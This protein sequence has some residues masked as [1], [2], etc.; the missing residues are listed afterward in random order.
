MV[1]SISYAALLAILVAGAYL[2]TNR[3]DDPGGA[4]ELYRY[5][6]VVRGD[7]TMTVT[8]TGRVNPLTTV[9][10]GSQV[11]GQIASLGADFNSV[12]KEGAVIARID[13]ASFEA[14]VEAASAQLAVARASVKMQRATLG[15][16]RAELQGAEAALLDAEREVKRLTALRRTRVVAQSDADRAV[17]TRDQA[18]ARRSMVTSRIAKQTAQ[19]ELA[20]AQVAASEAALRERRLE[21]DWTV[22]RSPVDGVVIDR[23]VEPGQ[24]VAASL[25][26]PV[27]FTLAQ[28][29]QRMQVEVSVDEADIGQV[30]QGQ[31]VN[32]TV[33]AYQ[34]RRFAGRVQQIRKVP[35]VVAN[36]V[37]YTVV[38]GAANPDYALL[39]GMTA[40]VEV[41]VGE[42]KNTLEVP[43]AALRFRPSNT[44]AAGAPGGTGPGA[45]SARERAR[46]LLQTL[47]EKLSLDIKQRDGVIAI[48]RE[49]AAA[50]RGLRQSGQSG[51]QLAQAVR[52]LRTQAAARI[53]ALLDEN[54][55]I[56][57][58]TLREEA[59]N[60]RRGRVWVPGP[61]GA[62]R[63]VT[64][65][66]GLSDGTVSELVRGDLAEGARVIVARR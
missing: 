53:E 33:D 35:E 24:T 21:L 52:G 7:L 26:A 1:R 20:L 2:W 4:K 49:T 44:G 36:V 57:Y 14:R 30:R 38:V 66:V 18:R 56:A 25:Q 41:V 10:V 16:L 65:T 46:A 5:A 31:G 37:T 50:I 47:Q 34:S 13:P 64:V 39:P 3:K 19:I 40:N 8:A 28:D 9:Q 63:A 43:D 17:A 12:V 62:P 61:D 27:L 23:N 55:K 11:S 51:D 59:R 15:E 22:I 32:F 48:F 58:R 54:Q 29:L 6:K 45:G 42:R 60:R